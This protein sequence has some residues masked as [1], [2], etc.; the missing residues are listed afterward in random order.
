MYF[1]RAFLFISYFW[2]VASTYSAQVYLWKQSYNTQTQQ[3]LKC[4]AENFDAINFLSAKITFTKNSN[5]PILQTLP[6]NTKCLNSL[7]VKKIAS[8]RIE[9]LN[10]SEKIYVALTQEISKKIVEHALFI[11]AKTKATEIQI[12]FD[13]PISKLANYA[14]W[15]KEIRK[16]LPSEIK[17]SIT[18]VM[19]QMRAKDFKETLPYC[20]YFVLQIHN[21]ANHSNKLK[22]FDFNKS[23]QAI[24]EA[25]NFSKDFIVAL[26]TYSHFIK[27]KNGKVEKIYSEN[28]NV[29]LAKDT[30]NFVA[31]RAMPI[32][33][34]NL[35]DTITQQKLKNYKGEIY[36][37][38][39]SGDE[40]SNWSISTLLNVMNNPASKLKQNFETTT[41]QKQHITEIF[42]HNTGNID[43]FMPK[44]I[45]VQISENNIY[46][47][48]IGDF[49]LI[50]K[51]TLNNSTHL[52]FSTTNI[53]TKIQPSKKIKMGWIKIKK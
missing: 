33:V 16:R 2:I 24:L 30:S 7:K 27:L 25:D 45:E 4:Y 3:T 35:R 6:I 37:R 34:A 15:L 13:C 23:I 17:L 9:T 26:P 14:E 40:I 18:A 12:D 11:S 48:G 39:P 19:S 53:C 51:K 38:L 50:S 28:F 31:V 1:R 44:N 29:N 21:I 41:E 46:A 36:Y 47:E 43:I 52:I 22:I 49:N 42:L 20:D 10:A 5:N 8:I 32:D